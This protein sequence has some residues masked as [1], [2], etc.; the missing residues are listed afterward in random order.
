MRWE[1]TMESSSSLI[2]DG[3][4]FEYTADGV[5]NNTGIKEELVFLYHMMHVD[6]AGGGEMGWMIR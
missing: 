6:L 1:D 4:F 3:I 5:G 2:N